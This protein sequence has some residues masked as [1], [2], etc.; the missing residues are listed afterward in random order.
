M[1]APTR[2][3]SNTYVRMIIKWKRICTLY[4]YIYLHA[5]YDDVIL[6]YP[7]NAKLLPDFAVSTSPTQPYPICGDPMNTSQWACR[8]LLSSPLRFSLTDLKTYHIKLCHFFS[9]NWSWSM[10]YIIYIYIYIDR[11]IIYIYIY[12]NYKYIY[13]ISIYIRSIYLY[14]IYIYKNIYNIFL[15]RYYM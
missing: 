6:F 10:G 11:Y 2:K 1:K 13:V 5:G 14:N 12:E 4:I 15:C 9:G 8:S 3:A 7:G